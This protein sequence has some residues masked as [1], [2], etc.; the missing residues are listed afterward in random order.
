MK[1]F[2]FVALLLAGQGGMLALAPSLIERGPLAWAPV[3]GFMGL[4][5]AGGAV[6]LLA[7]PRLL[8]GLPWPAWLALG[9]AMRLMWLDAPVV[10]NTDHWRYLWDGALV[11]HGLWPWG[12][13]P[14]AGVPPGFGAAGEAL[15]AEVNFAHLRS[16]YPATAQAGFALAH[17]MAPW[18]MLGLR[19]VT[20]AAEAATLCLGVLLL[21]R[22]GLPP[23][24]AAIWWCCPLVPVLLVGNAHVDALL[25]P[26]LLGALLA[27]LAG[28]GV[29]AG[30]LL[31]LAAGV[32]LWPVLLAP[33]LGR[34]LPPGARLGAALAL[35]VAGGATVLPLLA[36]AALPD[37]GLSAYAGGWVVNNSPFAW[38]RLVA[39]EALLRPAVAI[40][41]GMVALAVAWRAPPG[42]EGVLQG[43]MIVAAVVFYLSPAQYPWYAVW[44]MPLAA[45]LAFRPLL[46]PAA[47]LPLY[48]LWFP[49]DR[50]GQSAAFNQGVALLHVLP[51]AAALLV[52]WR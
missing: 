37:A 29:A 44:F 34:A 14:A 40:T 39:P 5:M 32:K 22:A 31:G 6:W 12:A 18:Q 17:F 26:L 28:R 3:L 13:P 16:I 41:A 45:L 33:L 46:L 23:A 47:L 1:S 36:T 2:L 30:L 51:I 24:R 43:A 48:W 35:G 21:R 11:A 10:L 8:P 52:R 50:A 25:P 7:V 9:V 4:A 38:L 20:L 49:M 42:P 19:L 15:A 27:T